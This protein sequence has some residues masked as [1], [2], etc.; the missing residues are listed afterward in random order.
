[1][2]SLRRTACGVCTVVRFTFLASRVHG[3]AARMF[4]INTTGEGV[5]ESLALARVSPGQIPHRMPHDVDGED[6][7][8]GWS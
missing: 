8:G 3:G 1:V 2:S 5:Q 4:E 7:G 6:V